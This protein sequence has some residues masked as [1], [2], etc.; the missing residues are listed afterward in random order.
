MQIHLK[1]RSQSSTNY[2]GNDAVIATTLDDAEGASMPFKTGFYQV[3]GEPIHIVILKQ[4]T[5][6]H[7]LK[8]ATRF[9]VKPFALTD[10]RNRHASEQAQSL[11]LHPS[12][13]RLS[14]V[15]QN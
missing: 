14:A 13:I 12:N 9:N 1:A 4:S 2:M 6:A 10:F 15:H 11:M 5:D 3:I 7:L 8:L